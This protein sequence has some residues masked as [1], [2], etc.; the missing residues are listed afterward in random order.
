[1]TQEPPLVTHN[2][3]LTTSLSSGQIL[4]KHGTFYESS[5]KTESHFVSVKHPNLQMYYRMVNTTKIILN[6]AKSGQSD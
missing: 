5:N 2:S 1:M 3:Q 6:W 4:L